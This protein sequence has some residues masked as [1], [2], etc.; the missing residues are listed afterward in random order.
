MSSQ[1]TFSHYPAWPAPVRVPLATL[2]EHDC[3]YLPGRA[4]TM[5][6]F[7]V[8]S[9]PPIL[10]HALMDAGFRRSGRFV[11]Q[12]ACDGCRACV[13][14][15]V[16]VERFRPSK[17]QRRCARKNADLD[18]RIGTPDPT[19]EKYD[20]YVRYLRDWHGRAGADNALTETCSSFG[21][22]REQFESF[23][24]DSPVETIEFTY[25]RRPDGLLVA[26]GICDVCAMSLSSVYFYFDPAHSWRGLGTYGALREL[27][28]AR[29]AEIPYYY[30][31]FWVHGCPSMQYKSDFRP[32]ESLHTDGVWR[33]TEPA[34]GMGE[35]QEPK[36]SQQRD[37]KGRAREPDRYS[38][39]PARDSG[40]AGQY[41]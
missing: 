32:N 10:Y 7:V 22:S 41:K 30:L 21:A 14:I 39:A 13:P 36:T 12:P 27:A 26:V 17:S 29:A 8:R 20:L 11:Y 3:A 37:E 2:S 5:R 35:V 28:H 19:D 24:Y 31:G 18:V 38:E 34:E 9:M 40:H 1:Q 25:R 16:P 6:A 4:T 33:A 23:L 15:R